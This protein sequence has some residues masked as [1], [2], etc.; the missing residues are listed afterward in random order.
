[1]IIVGE[2]PIDGGLTGKVLL[3]KPEEVKFNLE[4]ER[5]DAKMPLILFDDKQQSP[6]R[7]LPPPPLF[8]IKRTPKYM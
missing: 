6:I 1:M 7:I 8:K 5:Q 3:W 2:G 4:K